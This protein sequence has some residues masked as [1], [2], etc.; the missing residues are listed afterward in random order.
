M[1]PNVPTGIQE[2]AF[3]L[4]PQGL[5][6][7][8]VLTLKSG[9]VF[10]MTA[11]KEVSWQGNLYESIPCILSE[12]QLEADGKANRPS[13]SFANPEGVFTAA[14][15]T[16]LLDSAELK[17]YRILPSDLSANLNFALEETMRVSQVLSVTKGLIVTQLRDVYDGQTYMLPARAYYPPEFPHV[18]L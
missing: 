14:V 1:R 4:D 2:S 9:P 5:V 10:R 13:F 12:M 16:G 15:G 18:K 11:Q 17:R 6:S 7:L 3:D 8:Y